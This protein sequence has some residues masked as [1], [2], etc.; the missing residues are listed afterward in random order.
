MSPHELKA[1]QSQ[2]A[3]LDVEVSGLQTQFDTTK[4]DLDRKRGRLKAMKQKLHEALKQN[5]TP[6]VSEHAMLRYLERVKGI[7]LDAIRK[8][9]MDEHTE[10]LVKFTTSG[11]IKK[12]SHVLVIKNNVVITIET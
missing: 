1:L 11:R 5:D 12:D 3:Q 8:E 10:T 9:I 2:I 7:D 6:V 4:S